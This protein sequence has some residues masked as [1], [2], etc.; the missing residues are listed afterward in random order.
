MT[1]AVGTDHRL[2]LDVGP[3]NLE[4]SDVHALL[5][6]AYREHR[7]SLPAELSRTEIEATIR[8]VLILYGLHGGLGWESGVERHHAVRL[9]AWAWRLIERRL[10]TLIFDT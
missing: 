10:P 7:G 1:A 9:S 5:C 6:H 8:A 2:K 4:A 3:L